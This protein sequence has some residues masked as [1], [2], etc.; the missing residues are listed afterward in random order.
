M[1]GLECVQQLWQ[2][3]DVSS[4]YAGATVA[5]LWFSGFGLNDEALSYLPNCPSGIPC[6]AFKAERVMENGSARFRG[7][8]LEGVRELDED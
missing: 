7:P 3:D 1:S 2:A 6:T 8:L 4:W 5:S